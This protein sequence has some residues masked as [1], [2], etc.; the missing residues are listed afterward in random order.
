MATAVEATRGGS[1]HPFQHPHLGRREMEEEEIRIQA[2]WY[3]R[4]LNIQGPES[5]P[6]FV[7]AEPSPWELRAPPHRVPGVAG[8][9][10]MNPSG[11]V[12]AATLLPAPR[13]RLPEPTLNT[14]PLGP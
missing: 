4:I 9:P 2:E 1:Q 14:S 12:G 3:Y 13:T 7:P 5:S 8:G 11:R 6:R 10:T